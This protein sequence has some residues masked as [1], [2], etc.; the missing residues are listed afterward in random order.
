VSLGACSTVSIGK[1]AGTNGGLTDE[2]Q[3]VTVSGKAVV[4]NGASS[5]GTC[6][7]QADRLHIN[8]TPVD[9]THLSATNRTSYPISASS[10]KISSAAASCKA[11]EPGSGP[12]L[13]RQTLFG[14]IKMTL[15]F[16]STQGY[17][18]VSGFATNDN[19]PTGAKNANVIWVEGMLTKGAMAGYLLGGTNFFVPLVKDKAA[20]GTT[21]YGA[22][23]TSAA[24]GPQIAIGK[25]YVSSGGTL[26]GSAA[27]CANPAAPKPSITDIAVIGGFH[28]Y[29][30]DDARTF[31]D[32]TVAPGY[33]TT[34]LGAVNVETTGIEILG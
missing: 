25:G 24:Y 2:V 18:R 16:G 23:V 33:G 34:A 5:L 14:Q 1:A 22:T 10:F 29:V 32:T 6:E 4:V 11:T 3:A 13:T 31:L 19:G 26:I 12:D 30:V 15:P 8:A 27:G 20:L 7:L 28:D 9:P 17:L 21:P